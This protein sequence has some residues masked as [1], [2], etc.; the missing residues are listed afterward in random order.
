ML[1]SHDGTTGIK[2][3]PVDRSKYVYAMEG[4]SVKHAGNLEKKM[5]EA[6]SIIGLSLEEFGKYGE[7][8]AKLYE[9]PFDPYEYCRDVVFNFSNLDPDENEITW[10]DLDKFSTGKLRSAKKKFIETTSELVDVVEA[11]QEVYGKNAYGAFMGVLEYC[12]GRKY[13]G[14]DLKKFE[15]KFNSILLGKMRKFQ[16]YALPLLCK[17]VEEKCSVPALV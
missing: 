17:Y 2:V 10:E 15:T 3:I 12:N 4:Y 11:A 7:T 8:L 1:N 14:N 16:G 5:E 9:V 13:N 6:Y